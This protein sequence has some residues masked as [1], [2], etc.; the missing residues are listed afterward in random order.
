MT[1]LAVV[2]GP[3]RLSGMP[4][5]GAAGV[6]ARWLSAGHRLGQPSSET[7]RDTQLEEVVSIVREIA[8]EIKLRTDRLVGE[9]EISQDEELRI[10]IPLIGQD[11][12]SQELAGQVVLVAQALSSLAA[13]ILGGPLGSYVSEDVTRSLVESQSLLEA[14]EAQAKQISMPVQEGHE[15]LAEEHLLSYIEDLKALRDEAERLM[16]AT[17]QAPPILEQGEKEMQDASGLLV[18]IG[19]LTI[20]GLLVYLFVGE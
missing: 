19:A 4:P 16:V 9:L 11:F 8:V 5:V 18:T 2:R 17:E 7:Q 14:L 1:S 13:S 10:G 6:S 20:S 15:G 3:A 12:S